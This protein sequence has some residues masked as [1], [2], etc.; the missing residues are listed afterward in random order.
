[1]ERP[2][3]RRRRIAMSSGLREMLA[4]HDG[5]VTLAQAASVGLD[6]SAV[7]RRV[8]AGEWKRVGRGV[9]FVAERAMSTR[10]R[11]R[12]GC[13]SVGPRAVLTHQSA[14]WWH[15]LVDKPPRI[16]TVTAPRGR[17]PTPTPHVRVVH[18]DLLPVD[19]VQHHGLRVTAIPLTVLEAAVVDGTR[20]V[21]NALLRGRVS[22]DVLL[23]AHARYPGRRGSAVSARILRAAA[24]GARSE[25]ERI[26]HRLLRHACV[27]GW[28]AGYPTCGYVVDAAFPGPKLIVEIDGFAFHSDAESFQ[29]DR[30]RQNTLIAAGWT[31]LRFTWQDLTERPQ[32]VIAQ[33]RR[34]LRPTS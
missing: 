27:D 1:M 9:F 13:W 25:A 34:A 22:L 7:Q 6:R 5:V 10:A 15:G 17:H 19:V 18:R 26:L 24:S 30:T 32:Q 14:A 11:L 12:A 16:A 20:V 3:A 31:L 4:A 8:N 21:D 2:A 29:N 23:A 28:V 33:I